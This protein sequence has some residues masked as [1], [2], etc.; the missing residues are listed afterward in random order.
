MPGLA[1]AFGVAIA[2]GLLGLLLTIR[3]H[4]RRTTEAVE[5]AVPATPPT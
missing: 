1:I 5:F 4:H 2:V 3:L